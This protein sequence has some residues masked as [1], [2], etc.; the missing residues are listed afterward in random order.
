MIGGGQRSVAISP[1]DFNQIVVANDQ[2]VW[3]SVDGGLTWS[4]LNEGLPSLPVR[5]ILATP[6]GAAGARV[7]VENWDRPLEL[8]P[9]GLLWIPAASSANTPEQE[10]NARLSALLGAQITASVTAGEAAYAGASDGRIWFSRD[11]GATFVLSQAAMGVSGPVTR[12]YAD[13]AA[14]RTALAALGGS[15]VHV[16]RTFSG[17]DFWDAMDSDLPA[18]PAR[19]VTADLQSG[20]VYVATA[21]GVFWTATDLAVAGAPPHWTNLTGLPSTS[22]FDVQLDKA[23]VQLYVA[24]DGYGVY[25]ALAPHLRRSLR[26]ISAADFS[27]RAAAPG[28]LLTVAGAHVNGVRGGGLEYPVL[29]MPSD[30]ESQIQVPYGA[31]GPNVALSLQTSAGPVTF[32][33]QVQPVSP[34]IFVDRTGAPML[35]D[36]DS[37]LPVDGRNPAH[38]G[39]RLQIFASGLGRVRPDWPAGVATPIEGAS[40]EVAAPVRV[41]LDGAPIKV[42]RAILAPGYVGFYLV[43]AEL[44]PVANFGAAQ[45]YVDAGGQESNRVQ[46]VIEP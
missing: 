15:G 3:R 4:G 20:A 46:F 23:G 27:G 19:S 7:Q 25:A 16:L 33:I 28:S 45:L 24:V 37:G 14:P 39:G 26:V 12:L 38:S 36:A 18:S 40:H 21:E 5:R 30:D 35:Y 6:A 29:G 8:P 32:G 9:G 10:R 22:V 42:T 13:P 44:P 43:E 2:G 34:A 17:G 41:F 11:G 1:A 31:S